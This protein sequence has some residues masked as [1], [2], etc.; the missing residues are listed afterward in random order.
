MLLNLAKQNNKKMFAKLVISAK[1]IF[2]QH[3]PQKESKRV[4]YFPFVANIKL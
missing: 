3:K 4:F 2:Y 1:V